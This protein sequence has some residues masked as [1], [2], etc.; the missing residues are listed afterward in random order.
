MM[1]ILPLAELRFFLTKVDHTPICWSMREKMELFAWS[2]GT[3]WG[4]TTRLV[5]RISCRSSQASLGDP[6]IVRR[7]ISMGRYIFGE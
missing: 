7:F 3:I 5:I 2:T 6:S 1:V 4:I